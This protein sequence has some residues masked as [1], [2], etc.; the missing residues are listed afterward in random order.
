MRP[1]L[2]KIWSKC[3]CKD[4]C[5]NEDEDVDERLAV[6]PPE[7]ITENCG[8]LSEPFHIKVKDVASAAAHIHER[9][10]QGQQGLPFPIIPY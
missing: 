10:L 2:S 1:G 8:S 4:G 7:M 3:E 6:S 9:S 5:K